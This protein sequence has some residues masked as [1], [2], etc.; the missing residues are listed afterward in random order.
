MSQLHNLKRFRYFSLEFDG[1][2]R[3]DQFRIWVVKVQKVVQAWLMEVTWESYSVFSQCTL[4]FL[5]HTTTIVAQIVYIV[6][7]TLFF[8]LSESLLCVASGLW[9]GPRNVS[10]CIT[11]VNI[12]CFVKLVLRNFAKLVNVFASQKVIVSTRLNY[13]QYCISFLDVSKLISIRS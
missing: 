11:S 10:S 3:S 12:I 4:I 8:Q 1:V 2:L 7:L 6:L 5:W 13:R 9:S